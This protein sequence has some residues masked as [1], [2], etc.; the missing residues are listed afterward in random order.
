MVNGQRYGDGDGEG[1]G[2]GQA[3]R[4]GICS[5]VSVQHRGHWRVCHFESLSMFLQSVA[6][7]SDSESK[8]VFSDFE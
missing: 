1:E 2:S 6:F 3:I 7:G 4:Y 8:P 5:A